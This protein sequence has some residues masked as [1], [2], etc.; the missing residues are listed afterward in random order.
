VK[1]KVDKFEKKE[2]SDKPGKEKKDKDQKKYEDAKTKT[3]KKFM[4][5]VKEDDTGDML[6]S[7]CLLWYLITKL[8]VFLKFDNNSV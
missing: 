5:T 7:L 3:K 6:H 2:K 4:S 8:C 1:E